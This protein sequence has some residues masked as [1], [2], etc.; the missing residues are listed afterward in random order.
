MPPDKL[1]GFGVGCVHPFTGD[2]SPYVLVFNSYS[3]VGGGIARSGEFHYRWPGAGW[4]QIP[5]SSAEPVAYTYIILHLI[6]QMHGHLDYPKHPKPQIIP[7]RIRCYWKA[8]AIPNTV[9]FN[10]SC[11]HLQVWRKCCDSTASNCCDGTSCA[12]GTR[13]PIRSYKCKHQCLSRTI[14]W[15]IQ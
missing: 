5:Q 2:I 8:K 10:S 15:Y 7:S 9:S 4:P 6:V 13:T 3:H 14:P 12:T 11:C 1:Q